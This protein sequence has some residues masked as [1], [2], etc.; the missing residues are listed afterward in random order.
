MAELNFTQLRTANVE[1]CTNGF[2]HKL[3]AWSVAEWGA[4]AGGELGEALNIAKKLLR[5]RDALKGNKGPD[6]S[7]DSLKFRLAS[8]IADTII[9][10]D[11]WAASQDIDLSA[12]VRSTFN[13]KSREIGSA[14][15]I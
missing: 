8:E 11:L 4:A 7:L 15:R 12:A 6:T 2:G 10:L 3:D 5:H 13:S 14:V 9:Y 1:R